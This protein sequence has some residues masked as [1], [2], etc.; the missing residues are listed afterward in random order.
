MVVDRDRLR[1]FV[2]AD[3][4]VHHGLAAEHDLHLVPGDVA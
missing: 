1:G 3:P 2:D 4:G